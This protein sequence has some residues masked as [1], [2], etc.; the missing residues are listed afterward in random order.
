[1]RDLFNAPLIPG[2]A[3]QPDIVDAAEARELVDRIDREELVP[4][5]FQQWTGKRLTKS[6]GW[7]YDF[8]TGQSRQAAPIPDWLIDLRSR[9]AAFAGVEPERLIQALLIRYDVGAGI[10]WHRDRPVYD[11]IMGLS[12][13]APA[14][15]RLRRKE[16]DRWRRVS[17]PLE[18]HAAYHVSGEARH[19]WEHSIAE[20]AKTRHSITF[21]TASDIGLRALHLDERG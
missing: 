14:V 16:G 7:N 20:M 18:P 5:R 12:L 10:G 19:G 15:L 2:L 13:G 4:F 1:M 11:Q 3:T 6:F 21:R 9:M 17:L 8:E